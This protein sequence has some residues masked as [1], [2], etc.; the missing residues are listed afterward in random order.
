MPPDVLI[1]QLLYSHQLTT[2][3]VTWGIDHETEAIQAYIKYQNNIG[4]KGLSVTA[5]G[6]Y[7]NPN[8]PF[9]G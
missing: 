3:A 7:I 4:H 8:Y 5:A 1:K 2:Q 9:L 6:F